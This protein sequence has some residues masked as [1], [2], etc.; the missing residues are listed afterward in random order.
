MDDDAAHSI[1]CAFEKDG[2]NGMIITAE[3]VQFQAEIYGSGNME[4]ILQAC[5]DRCQEVLTNRRESQMYAQFQA[6]QEYLSPDDY[7][8]FLLLKEDLKQEAE[9]DEKEVHLH[10]IETL[11]KMFPHEPIMNLKM[12]FEEQQWD[13][14]LTAAVLVEKAAAFPPL[15]NTGTSITNTI[16]STKEEGRTI[17]KT[18]NLL[19]QLERQFLRPQVL[20]TDLISTLWVFCNENQDEMLALIA[21]VFPQAL[22][23]NV[24]ADEDL[25]K[26]TLTTPPAVSDLREFVTVASQASKRKNRKRNRKKN[27]KTDEG[28][29]IQPQA[30]VDPSTSLRL[31][32]EKG[33]EQ[34][35][36]YRDQIQTCRRELQD[37]SCSSSS[38]SVLM[39]H[40]I[41]TRLARSNQLYRLR[42]TLD[43]T[44]RKLAHAIVGQNQ[45]QL[46]QHVPIDCHGLVVKEA[47]W[48]L[49][50]CLEKCRIAR[51]VKFGLIL[52]KG[53]H[54]PLGKSQLRLALVTFLSRSSISHVFD[55]DNSGLLWISLR[56][57]TK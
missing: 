32:D 33:Q 47:L 53:H 40:D 52:G 7:L 44:Q 23:L 48:V 18:K 36:A 10:P 14:E 35:Q 45:S 20:E 9:E 51:I 57:S 28:S 8:L 12:T 30:R 2:L 43:E 55:S 19:R 6:L 24:D 25:D 21:C 46:A 37:L 27:R 50:H 41:H 13:L 11:A 5:Q 17:V 42:Q 29:A 38:Q 49:K 54:S 56:K 4:Q 3:F 15:D 22:A 26:M 16:P 39:K 1:A 31:C 34:L